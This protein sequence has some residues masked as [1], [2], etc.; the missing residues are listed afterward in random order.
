MKIIITESQYKELTDKNIIKFCYSI[1]D[2][3]KKRG[4]KP[5]IDDI[6]YDVTKIRKNSNDDYQQIRPIWYDYNGGYDKLLQELKDEI[7]HDEIQIKGSSNLDMMIFVND[8]YSDQQQSVVDIVCNIIG[9][10]VDGYVYNED[11]ELYDRVPNTD[12][13]DQYNLLDG[14]EINDYEAFLTDEIYSYFSNN[15]K[16]Y[17]LPIYVEIMG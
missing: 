5:Y 15:L 1:W 13:V 3:Q 6:I 14:D 9:G 16:N 7:L 2:Q 11:T 10:T 4:E 17:E 8:V 12:I